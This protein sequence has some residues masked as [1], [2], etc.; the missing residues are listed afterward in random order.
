[1]FHCTEEYHWRNLLVYHIHCAHF[2]LPCRL[3]FY[4][5]EMYHF[6][7]FKYVLKNLRRTRAAIMANCYG[8]QGWHSICINSS[9]RIQTNISKLNPSDLHHTQRSLDMFLKK[10]FSKEYEYAFKSKYDLTSSFK[11]KRFEKTCYIYSI[12]D[13]A[14]FYSI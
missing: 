5:T 13:I 14:Y 7:M 10:C 8:S 4:P 3:F 11:N 12:T 9:C 2:W 1:M 6:R